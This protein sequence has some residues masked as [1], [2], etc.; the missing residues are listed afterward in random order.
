MVFDLVAE[1]ATAGENAR[2]A[3]KVTRTSALRPAAASSIGQLRNTEAARETG[4][5]QAQ[6]LAPRGY[7]PLS[8]PGARAPRPASA[9]H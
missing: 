8:A 9:A 1:L 3:R 7:A 4:A 2:A 6:Q 5:R